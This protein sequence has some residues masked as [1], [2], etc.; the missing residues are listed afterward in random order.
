MWNRKKYAAVAIAS[1]AFVAIASGPASAQHVNNGYAGVYGFGWP[2]ALYGAYGYDPNVTYGYRGSYGAASYGGWEDDRGA[3]GTATTSTSGRVR[4][5]T[6]R[7]EPKLL[8]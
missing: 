1:A 2:P 7:R 3:S 8:E 5:L 6:R 4:P